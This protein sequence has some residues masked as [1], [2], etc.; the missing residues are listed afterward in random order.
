[1]LRRMMSRMDACLL[2]SMWTLLAPALFARIGSD[3]E[4]T[5][6]NLHPARLI[7][8]TQSRKKQQKG[9]KS[10]RHQYAPGVMSQFY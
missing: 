7:G 6:V 3:G 9:K 1:M 5:R 2:A 10:A 8:E 4:M